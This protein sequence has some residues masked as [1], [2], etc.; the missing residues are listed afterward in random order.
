MPN[1]RFRD[2]KAAGQCLAA[3]LGE[4]AIEHPVVLGIAPGGVVVAAEV[5]DRL[6][7]QLGVVVSK[8]LEAPYQPE[9]ALGAVT[10]D[11]AA[12]VDSIL[13]AEV[14]ASRQ[15][16]HE[17]QGRRARQAKR[18]QQ[19]MD[20]PRSHAVSGRDVLVVADGLTTGAST[21]AAIRRARAAGAARVIVATPV[22]PPDA[23]E[24]LREEAVEIVCLLEEVSFLSVAQFYRDCSPVDNV[25]VRGLLRRCKPD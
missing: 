15:Y 9:L 13:A 14:G 7:A 8:K 21:I 23:L 19:A 24:K 22:A 3:R 2:R 11:G 1:E 5:A 20:G 16:L 17:E 12:Y 18:L 10:A 6:G 4:C 25:A